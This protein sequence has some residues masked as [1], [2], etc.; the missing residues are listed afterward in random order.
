MSMK[1]TVP[2]ENIQAQVHCWCDAT[3]FNGDTLGVKLA[4]RMEGA[5]FF[6]VFAII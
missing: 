2:M 3:D 1:N 4:Q 6:I 5:K